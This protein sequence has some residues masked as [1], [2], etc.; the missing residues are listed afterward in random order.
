MTQSSSKQIAGFSGGKRVYVVP[1][2]ELPFKRLK[3]KAL[4][5]NHWARLTVYGLTNLASGRIG[6]DNIFIRPNSM[7]RN[8]VEEFFVFL[9]G[10]KA[11]VERLPDDS[12]KVLALTI[13]PGYSEIT[14][15]SSS[16]GIYK[17]RKTE[18]GAWAT[19]YSEKNKISEGDGPTYVGVCDGR[20]KNSKDAAE[21]VANLVNKAPGAG[22]PFFNSFDLHYT[23]SASKQS[24][25]GLKQYKQAINPL[26]NSDIMG[27]SIML[28]N[29]MYQARDQ[30]KVMWVSE[31]G[32]SAILTQAMKILSDKGIKLR[33]HSAY[34]YR[35]NTSTNEAV[36]YA[37]SLGLNLDRNFAKTTMFD[38][39]GNRDQISMI[40]NRYKNEE[41]Y[42]AGNAA[43]DFVTQVKNVQGL[44]A[45]AVTGF[46]AMGVTL[47]TPTIPV[48]TQIAGILGVS[49]GALKIGDSL[50]EN[51]APRIYNK[52][53]GKI[54]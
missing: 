30:E 40:Y 43:F 10:C 39:V 8:G 32:G 24:F 15:E 5:G 37:H 17:A 16:T 26:S 35:P 18:G 27:S 19:T 11:T 3:E 28:A 41:N 22:G 33:S 21:Y 14:S 45:L 4:D 20:Y 25:G 31:F 54:K 53:I 1:A 38:Y 9:P 12:Y 48:L 44:K 29:A 42:K 34:L 50:A 36:K 51:I 23:N 2:V 47:A 49:A 52:H 7:V 46:A 13:D 6:K